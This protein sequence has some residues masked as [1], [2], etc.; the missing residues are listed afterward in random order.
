[1]TTAFGASFVSVAGLA[2]LV[3]C[4][5]DPTTPPAPA[6]V[7]S[8]EVTP[9]TAGV[10]IGQ[11]LQ[12]TVKVKDAA[13][14]ELADRPVT[15]TSGA[16]AQATVTPTGLVT[17]LGLSDMVVITATSED[18]GASA[19]I[20]VVMDIAG[21]WNFTENIEWQ[22]FVVGNPIQGVYTIAAT[23]SDTGSYRLTQSGT[24]ISGTLSAIGE[25]LG[26][27]SPQV[28][29]GSWDNTALSLAI[30]NGHL[31]GTH[32]AFGI[33]GGDCVY[34]GD[35]TG[36]PTPKMVGTFACPFSGR[37]SI[38]GTWEAT[39]GGAPVSSV[40]VRWDAQTVA[41]GAVQLFAVPRDASGHVL[42]RA[43]T[44]ASDN[45]S[46]ATVSENGLASALAA[47]SAR[48]TATS[49]A[50]AGSAAVAADL[51][52]FRSVSAGGHGCAVTTGGSAYC[53]GWGGNGE[54][55]IGFR[56]PGPEPLAGAQTPRAV[57]G[58]HAFD[59]VSAGIFHSCGLTPTHD[60]YCWGDNSH[61]QLGDGSTTS[62]LV[63]VPVTGGHQFASVTVGF[64]HTCG[65]T[66]A[67]AVYCWGNNE[68]GQLGG[69]GGSSSALP[70]LV[71][72]G[73]LPFQSVRAG[74]YHTCGV[75]PTHDAYCW[76]YNRNGQV[77]N[78]DT[79]FAVTS[80]AQVVGGHSFV[81]VGAGYAHS[82][83]MESDSTAYCWGDGS[84]LG[85]GS[86]NGISPT[87]RAVTGGP[88]A[89][90]DSALGV[91]QEH[92]C[93][94]TSTG[95]ALCWGHNN[96]GELGDGSTIDRTTPAQVSGGLSFAA[97]SVGH[98]VT[99]AVTSTAVAFCW[100]GNADG[101]L[102]APAPESC[103]VDQNGTTYPCATTPVPVMGQ[104]NQAGM[105]AARSV[106][107]A[108]PVQRAAPKDWRPR[109]WM[110][111]RFAPVAPRLGAP[112]Q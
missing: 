73:S 24:E 85:D 33:A 100:G 104:A 30:T 108:A 61:G 37:I 1:M 27:P 92:T 81:A 36:P 48:I 22:W 62:S 40:P 8:V 72:D 18:K 63:P 25:C 106:R 60:A 51:V 112:T 26:H 23:C 38:K 80:P 90:T 103:V 76:G 44:W 107:V 43:V 46:V 16:P 7:A 59:L 32:I 9:P 88:F 67:N 79:S 31:S 15:W 45:P 68:V 84:L 20:V 99:C 82:C 4:G 97:I 65:L 74:L 64:Y 55:G 10:V 111:S 19:T 3:A 29:V 58:G 110:E 94:L 53:W 102:G 21:E 89:T 35:L 96:V 52:G 105:L 28:P 42:S 57:A 41:G 2:L 66:T 93:A 47:G 39:P 77:G 54:L 75:T 12:L 13:G 49:E 11:T 87:P 78:G 69:N 5:E 6:P 91:G 71:G 109:R 50:M 86:F 83:A 14:H 17:A 101:R 70:L 56:S 95:A 34:S 98:F